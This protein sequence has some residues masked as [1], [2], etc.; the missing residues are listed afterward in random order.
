MASGQA[1]V[2]FNGGAAPGIQ[3]LASGYGRDG[4]QH[5]EISWANGDGRIT[6]C[7]AHVCNDPRRGPTSASLLARRYFKR[8]KRYGYNA[9]GSLFFMGVSPIPDRFRHPILRRMTHDS[10]KQKRN[11]GE[12]RASRARTAIRDA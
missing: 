2:D 6:A 12:H 7:I 8:G 9:G 3:D 1:D 5:R 10:R 11:F 4:G